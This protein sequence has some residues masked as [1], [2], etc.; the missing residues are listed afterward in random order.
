MLF[1]V[2]QMSE[3]AVLYNFKLNIFLCFWAA[4]RTQQD[5]RRCQFPN[6][7]NLRST[8]SKNINPRSGLTGCCPVVRSWSGDWAISVISQTAEQD[9]ISEE[10]I[11]TVRIHMGKQTHARTHARWLQNNVIYFFRIP[12][13]RFPFNGVKVE[14]CFKHHFRYKLPKL[15]K[16]KVKVLIFFF[17]LNM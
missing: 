6:T 5:I 9:L 8:E 3:F 4:G 17:F 14:S 12:S 16:I 13:K 1:P 15:N 11:Q 10:E 7:A 2:S